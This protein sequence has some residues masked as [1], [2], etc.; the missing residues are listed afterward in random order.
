MKIKPT[1]DGR[2]EP[3]QARISRPAL[4]PALDPAVNIARSCCLAL[5]GLL[6]LHLSAPAQSGQQNPTLQQHPIEELR[7]T[8]PTDA[9]EYALGPG[10]EIKFTVL[11]RPELSGTHILGPDGRITLPIAGSIAVGGL[12]REAASQASAKALLAFY[13]EPV[14]NIEITKY[15][16]NRILLLGAVE[17]PGVL[18]FDGTPTLLEAITRGGAT[19][20]LSDKSRR[21][22]MH[23]IIYRGNDQIGTVNLKDVFRT[24]DIRLHRNDIVYVPGDQERLIS[25]LGEVKSPGPVPL[26]DESTLASLLA[27]AGGLTD[28]AGNAAVQIIHP[29]TG[30]VRQITFK[31]LLTPRGKDV[32]LQVGDIVYVP[33]SGIAKVGYF[34]QQLSPAAQ[35]ATIGTLVGR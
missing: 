25:I 31:E 18:Y 5:S 3:G 13:T 20:A 30:A 14:V 4:G 12:S 34:L 29:E 26:K 6:L 19:G 33:K 9:D 24:G 21:M 22:P 27:D 16:S 2:T 10:D 11:G 28:A 1:P 7:R 23:C 35:M 15:G 17:H 8:Q 32:T